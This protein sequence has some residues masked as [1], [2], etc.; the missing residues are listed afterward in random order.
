KGNI[1]SISKVGLTVLS[2]FQ[3]GFY[4]FGSFFKNTI[5]SVSQLKK[6]RKELDTTR[7]ELDR[8]KKIIQDL[9]QLNN[10]NDNLRKLLELK[11]NTSYSTVACEIIARDPAKQFEI[12]IINKGSTSGIKENM[13]V[14]TY[15]E[16]YNALIGKTVEV[17]PFA[18]KVIT[19]SNPKYF[20]GALIA[21][22]DTHCIIQGSNE[23][24]NSVKLLYLPKTVEINLEEE[25]I[26]YTTGDSV[27]YPRGLRIGKIKKIVPSRRYE[28]Y[29]EAEV[30][31]LTNLAN[32]N[33]VL[34][35]KV[36]VNKDDYYKMELEY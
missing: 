4:S 36:D 31:T 3:N 24:Y 23:K 27:F 21:P 25:N 29:N 20:V 8:Y 18:S 22:S 17:T 30:T 33:Y 34:V 9:N 2:T 10:E 7:K 26:V 5:N 16:G 32:I 13:P 28:L 6:I 11:K 14:I 35:L 15:T 19:L 1:Q 12:I